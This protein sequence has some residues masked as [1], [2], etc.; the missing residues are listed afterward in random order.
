MT[1]NNI[2]CLLEFCLK[3]SSFLFQGRYY[4]QVEGAAMS[5]PISPILANLYFEEFEIKALNTAPHP[6]SLWR[7]FVDDTSVVIQSAHKD[8]FIEHINSI[9]HRIQFTM[10]VFFGHF[11]H[12]PTRWQ[13]Q[14][15]IVQ[16]THPHWLVSAVGQSPYHCSK[17]SVVNTLHH[18]ARSVFCNPQL[19]QNEEENL[20]RLLIENKCPVWALNRVKMKINAT[21]SQDKSK[22]DTNICANVISNS[23]RPY[24]VVPYTKGLSE[25]LKNVS[26]KHGVQAHFKGGN[27]IRSLLMAPSD[28]HPITKKSG[29]IYRYKCDR[30]ESNDEYVGESSRTFGKGFKELLKVPSPIYDHFN[31]TGHSTTIDNHN[32]VGREDQNLIRTIK[33][34]KNIRVKNSSLDNNIL[35]YHLPHIWDEI[36]LNISELKLI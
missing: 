3:N 16:K 8:N 9:D 27:T 33:E 13:F 10:D 1:V 5:S 25:S 30:E 4:E 7:R 35:K 23:Q 11:G 32:I 18:R 34:A 17:Y 26:R 36:L 22:R 19:L 15:Y 2:I 20:Q 12:T 24:I 31:I 29:I 6:P 28:K 21:T 14:H